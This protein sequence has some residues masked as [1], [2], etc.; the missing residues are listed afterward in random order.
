MIDAVPQAADALPPD[1]SPGF[2][3]IIAP[4]FNKYDEV[5]QELA[6][7]RAQLDDMNDALSEWDEAADDLKE[8]LKA[9]AI[10]GTVAPIEFQLQGLTDTI[11][12]AEHSLEN[13]E[14]ACIDHGKQSDSH[15][16]C[17]SSEA[18]EFEDL[19]DCESVGAIRQTVLRAVALESTWYRQMRALGD[20]RDS[21]PQVGEVIQGLLGEEILRNAEAHFIP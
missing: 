6:P 12:G 9:L 7:F 17:P 18:I 5:N 20:L 21:V 2:R 14:D 13:D 16:A 11:R 15:G 10:Q 1:K 3:Q 4:F 19:R 8:K